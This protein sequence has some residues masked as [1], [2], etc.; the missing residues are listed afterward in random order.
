MAVSA[1]FEAA[2]AQNNYKL[3][4]VIEI[5]LGNETRY[6][7]DRN[8]SDPAG[9]Y[10]YLM[11]IPRTGVSKVDI[12]EAK[13][14]LG[15]LSFTLLDKD[16]FVTDDMVET[17][18]L[19]KKVSLYLLFDDG[20]LTFA[21]DAVKVFTG[22]IETVDVSQPKIT[23]NASEIRATLGKPIFN[24][25]TNLDGA[26]NDSAT[27]ITVDSTA[28]FKDSG[29][30]KIDD[31][32]INYTGKT[33]TTFT[34]CTRGSQSS[35]AASHDDDEEIIQVFVAS[36][37][38]PITLVLQ[39][40][41]SITG[42]GSN[43]ATYDVLLDGAGLDPNDID[44][45]S[46]TDIRDAESFGTFDFVID[47]ISNIINFIE[48]ELLLPTVTR[49][50][51]SFEGKLTLVQLDQ[52][53]VS[54]VVEE[55][56]SDSIVGIPKMTSS[57]R[58]IV[59]DV[60]VKYNYNHL[61]DKYE[62]V[63]RT[64]DQ[65][66][67]SLYGRP[68]KAIKTFEFRGMTTS[69]QASG[70]ADDYLARNATPTPTIRAKTFL[71]KRMITP[72]S[73]VIF[74]SKN[75]SNPTSGGTSFSGLLEVISVSQNKDLVDLT[76]AYTR[77]TVGRPAFI[78]PSGVISSKSS[79]TVFDLSAGGSLFEIGFFV[80][81]WDSALGNEIS[82]YNDFRRTKDAIWSCGKSEG[83]VK[84]SINVT[85]GS[86]VLSGD[87]A[88][89]YH[90][91]ANFKLKDDGA[92]RIK[93]TP[94]YSGTPANDMFF[95]SVGK[96]GDF[97]N[98]IEIYHDTNGDL[99]ARVFSENETE[100]VNISSAW[101]PTSGTTYELELNVDLGN[102]LVG[103]TG[104]TRLFVDGV[105]H[106]STDTTAQS[107][108]NGTLRTRD[109]TYINLGTDITHTAVSNFEIEEIIIFKSVQHTSGYTPA[110]FNFTDTKDFREITNVDGNEITIASAFDVTIDTSKHHI[111][112]SDY[113]DVT[114][115]QL[116]WGYIAPDAGFADTSI[117]YT[118]S[119]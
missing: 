112:F 77:F 103:Q 42:D 19:N 40:L 20:V 109:N 61:T 74:G 15:S 76:M 35:T 100:L 54:S 25:I 34:G 56:S 28:T 45:D 17:T 51:T 10:D 48:D 13:T 52:S 82:F 107:S 58:A 4:H 87:S 59:N 66:S 32:Y 44:I 11:E 97:S 80:S 79:E 63:Y 83:L 38:N 31:E 57:T 90:A 72:G 29:T 43:N 21:N 39:L 2:I 7:T 22:Y 24:G 8:V 23:F 84:G 114:S 111:I 67:I 96:L 88:L 60:Y 65:V 98:A 49:I 85:G 81:L 62:D 89:G 113:G 108:I 5:E 71:T 92:I 94:L 119:L 95:L 91:D 69:V 86:L 6:Y 3:L 9:S 68:P 27:T 1:N 115:A 106:G 75:L 64:T 50:V 104:A 73:D 18:Y 70:F 102:G 16:N 33:D 116:F 26:I 99:I 14:T 30:I 53:S 118:I 47:D 110:D 55:I 117:D 37:I 105:Q 12:K 93:V 46:F 36:S 41:M 78:S 101:S